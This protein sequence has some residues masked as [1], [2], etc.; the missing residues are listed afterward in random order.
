[1]E[2]V[3]TPAATCSEK[4][5]VLWG[6]G[7]REAIP[8]LEISISLAVTGAGASS[9]QRSGTELAFRSRMQGQPP[10][11]LSLLLPQ[12]PNPSQAIFIFS[13]FV[14]CSTFMSEVPVPSNQPG[15]EHQTPNPRPATLP[16]PSQS[17]EGMPPPSPLQ[18][19]GFEDC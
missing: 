13:N 7:G 1:M 5:P 15:P 17:R 8:P 11:L 18:I 12:I 14:A 9:H 3:P 19:S 4:Q 6:P 16:M 2:P 10:R